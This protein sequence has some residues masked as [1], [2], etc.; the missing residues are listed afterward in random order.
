MLSAPT[1][2]FTFLL[3]DAGASHHELP[4]LQKWTASGGVPQRTKW[5]EEPPW[6][7]RSQA[8]ALLTSAGSEDRRHPIYIP[9]C[10]CSSFFFFFFCG[11][12]AVSSWAEVKH[13]LVVQMAASSLCNAQPRFLARP[14]LR[15]LAEQE[16]HDSCYRCVGR[17]MCKTDDNQ[18][19]RS[20]QKNIG[21]L[22]NIIQIHEGFLPIKKMHRVKDWS[23]KKTQQQTFR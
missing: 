1:E 15:Q 7:E 13:W 16:R 14:P 10:S 8:Y 18:I 19:T 6:E 20:D 5:H 21:G 2:F 11:S 4:T 9:Y 22:Q 23:E 17:K 12:H 3:E